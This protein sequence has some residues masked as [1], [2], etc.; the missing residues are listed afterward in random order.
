[1]KHVRKIQNN[2]L[3][4]LLIMV[5]FLLVLTG[6]QPFLWRFMSTSA[7][8]L[9]DKRTEQEQYT[10]LQ[11]QLADIDRVREEQTELVAQLEAI[12]PSLHK[13]TQPV[14]RLEQLADRRNLLLAISNIKELEPLDKK[15]REELVPLQITLQAQGPPDQLLGYIDDVEHA[16]EVVT[17]SSWVI[18]V[19]QETGEDGQSRDRHR[20]DMNVSFYVRK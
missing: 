2:Q 4:P 20:L 17:I 11:Q 9:Q 1:M 7:T 18:D 19:Y 14:E 5:V 10:N 12:F 16:Q 13:A 15:G 8:K 6:V 3:R